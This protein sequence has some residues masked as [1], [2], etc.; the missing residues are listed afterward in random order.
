MNDALMINT[1]KQRNMEYEIVSR[2]ILKQNED[3]QK[4]LDQI[5]KRFD[6]LKN[7]NEQ[8][9][10][11]YNLKS[12]TS[13]IQLQH[14]LDKAN[15]YNKNLYTLEFKKHIAATDNIKNKIRNN[16]MYLSRIKCFLDY[17]NAKI[18]KDSIREISDYYNLLNAIQA[19]S[20]NSVKTEYEYYN[21]KIDIDNDYLIFIQLCVN[22]N[23]GN[24]KNLSKELLGEEKKSVL[25]KR[26]QAKFKLEQY[27]D[28]FRTKRLEIADEILFSNIL[29]KYNIDDVINEIYPKQT[30]TK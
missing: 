12:K 19:Q 28:I 26:E 3:L 13:S 20:L 17:F 30:K 10:I 7:R 6:L 9:T 18:N 27:K 4:K 16:N 5:N 1:L 22:N 29:M 8:E 25:E 23:Q 2:E 21:N 24:I 15:K 14:Q 11:K